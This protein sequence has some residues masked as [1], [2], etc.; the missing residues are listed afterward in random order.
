MTRGAMAIGMLTTLLWGAR[1]APADG[2]E[3]TDWRQDGAGVVDT[4]LPPRL[5][6]AWST[7]TA[8]WS[9]ASPLVLEDVIVTTEE[10]DTL[11][12]I[13]KKTGMLR[14][15]ERNPYTLTL[16][17]QEQPAFEAQ[18][19]AV[20]VLQQKLSD[21][22]QELSRIK[23]AL[24]ADPTNLALHG[25]SSDLQQ[26][27]SDTFE[28][29]DALSPMW[30]IDDREAIGYA[31]HPVVS[32]G[33]TLYALFGT[34]VMTARDTQDGTLRWATWLGPAPPQMRGYTL[35][36]AAAPLLVD[37]TLVVAHATLRGLDPSTGK[38]RWVGPAY[39]DYGSPAV[40]QPE[41]STA[42]VATPDGHLVRVTDGQVVA[43]GLGDLW[44]ASPVARG[45]LVAWFG[46]HND[47]QVSLGHRQSV[48]VHRVTAD[49]NAVRTQEV[50]ATE[51]DHKT[52]IYATPSFV[53]GRLVVIDSV[54]QLLQA[55]GTTR[56]L[57]PEARF[58]GAT[59]TIYSSGIWGGNTVWSGSAEG[60]IWQYTRE[61]DVWNRAVL[62]ETADLRS[63]PVWADGVLYVRT[64]EALEAWHA[65]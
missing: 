17:L 63:T 45:D 3:G 8:A 62:I 18:T 60:T 9:N 44:Y 30:P 7:P 65:P 42:L 27:M 49:A 22:R 32:D 61:A 6:R 31:G 1:I 39:T 20:P 14:W 51:I 24:R 55:D 36:T 4:S 59:G 57:A 43:S 23:R 53:D 29:L 21:V 47:V 12:A 11:I 40:V 64:L 10:P 37:D 2:G 16:P 34:G 38:T 50:M 15:R 54:G 19:E 5:T 25:T 48:R 46:G 33:T 56:R 28:A 26:T 13:D 41:G 52:S 58:E 35:G